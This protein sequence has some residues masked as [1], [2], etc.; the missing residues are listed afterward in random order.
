MPGNSNLHMSRAGRQDEFY[1]QLSTIEDELCHYREYFR[2]KIVFCNADDPAIGE[3]GQ[4]HYGDGQG[5]FTS[6]FFRYFQLNFM[7]LGLKKLITTHFDPHKR[8]YKFEIVSGDAGDQIGLPGYVKTYLDGNGDFRSPECIALLDECDLVVTN[9]PFSLMREYIPLLVEKGKQFIILGN[10]NHITLK[11][12]LHLFMEGKMWLGYNS[13]HF[14]FNVPEYYEEKKTDFKIIDGQKM[15]RMGNCCWFTNLDI[16][17]RHQPLDLFKRYTPAEYPTY[18]NYPAIHINRVCDI[19]CD[20]YGI[21]AVP[22]TFMA[23]FCPEQFEIL[24]DNRYHDGQEFADDINV[25]N[26]KTQYRRILVKRIDGGQDH[27]AD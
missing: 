12:L 5:A 13:G 22:I 11:E 21:M 8:S 1:T 16:Q 3:D 15:R 27:D 26:G 14:W 2:G 9:P 25:I 23:Q 4:D 6:N 19:P 24:G 7:E 17:I 10:M 20:Y 18:D